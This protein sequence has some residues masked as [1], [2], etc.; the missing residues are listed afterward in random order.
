M[1]TLWITDADYLV[2]PLYTVTFALQVVLLTLESVLKWRHVAGD[3]EAIPA[4][5]R[6]GVFGRMFFWWLMPLFFEGYKRD[7]SMEDLFA[8]D[9]DLKGTILWER[10]QKSWNAGEIRC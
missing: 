2:A 7:L 5:E 3:P 4:E 6:Q 10:L 1:R 8:I 9:E